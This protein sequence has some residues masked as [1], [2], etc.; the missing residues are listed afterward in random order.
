MYLDILSKIDMK[1]QRLAYVLQLLRYV[2][3]YPF[4]IIDHF[5]KFRYIVFAMYLHIS[6][7]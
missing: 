4:Q 6:F 1:T 5:D 3:Y 2:I 7:I